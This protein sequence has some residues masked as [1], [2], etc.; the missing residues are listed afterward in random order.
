MVFAW[1]SASNMH[2]EQSRIMSNLEIN[3]NINIIQMVEISGGALP[4]R[5]DGPVATESGFERIFDAVK[6]RLSGQSGAAANGNDLPAGALCIVPISPAINILTP[7]TVEIS[8]DVIRSYAR[9][10]GLN[11]AVLGTLLGHGLDGTATGN[12]GQ[13]LTVVATPGPESASPGLMPAVPQGS[14]APAGWADAVAAMGT[15]KPPARGVD[16]G[17]T[18]ELRGLDPGLPAGRIA[19]YLAGMPETPGGTAAGEAV[20]NGFLRSVENASAPSPLLRPD[21]GGGNERGLAGIRAG[22]VAV[23]SSAVT[24]GKGQGVV[25]DA[26]DAVARFA[27]EQSLQQTVQIRQAVLPIAS[28]VAGQLAQSLKFERPAALLAQASVVAAKK[29]DDLPAAGVTDAQASIGLAWHEEL[30]LTRF[31][32][33]RAAQV[34]VATAGA[35]PA[36]AGEAKTGEG[37]WRQERAQQDFQYQKLSEQMMEAVGRRITD[38][39][40]KGVWQMSFQLRPERLGKVD[41]R[42]GMANGTI[43]AAFTSS[44]AETRQLLDSGLTRLKEVLQGAGFEVGNLQTGGQAM[45]DRGGRQ[46]QSG[47]RETGFAQSGMIAPAMRGA[48]PSAARPRSRLGADG[49]DLIV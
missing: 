29:A 38:Q 46:S 14:S 5:A 10:Q 1:Q 8:D 13:S 18:K 12:V 35:T 30:D 27:A 44:Q 28:V 19:G 2:A 33:E 34:D 36:N 3:K 11:P 7:G 20:A 39:V 4:A 48:E 37:L 21:N 6:K 45:G 31:M 32:P 9:Q 23:A 17:L 43:D 22:A 40:A 25:A 16:T 42:L 24:A 15:E 49:I 47:G 26:A 41:V